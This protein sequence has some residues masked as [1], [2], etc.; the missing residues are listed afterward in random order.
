MGV[1]GSKPAAARASQRTIAE[2]GPACRQEHPKERVQFT[3]QPSPI[4]W[5]SDH[6]YLPAY[7]EC[8]PNYHKP[9][10]P[11]VLDHFRNGPFKNFSVLLSRDVARPKHTLTFPTST[12]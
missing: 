7:Q 11:A 10:R 9:T 12:H 1:Q 5:W 4:D 3:R 6:D 8:T 2:T